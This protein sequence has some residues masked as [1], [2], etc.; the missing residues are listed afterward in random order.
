M[1]HKEEHASM[2]TTTY[3]GFSV[4]PKPIAPFD[5]FP[6]LMTFLDGVY[7]HINL[8][9]DDLSLP[10]LEKAASLQVQ[11]NRLPAC[12]VLSHDCFYSYGLDGDVSRLPVIP[13]CEGIVFYALLKL[14]HECDRVEPMED[15]LARLN[16]YA[17]LH[18]LHRGTNLDF[19]TKKGSALFGQKRVPRN[20]PQVCAA[21]GERKGWHVDRGS[22]LRTWVVPVT[23]ACENDTLCAS[24]ER[25]LQPHKLGA[26]HY[27]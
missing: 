25:P 24:C 4:S 27:G 7:V 18:T 12:L 3:P 23:C 2:A 14:P 6:Y 15:R 5:G 11:R 9:S 16:R 17:A 21:C 1:S 8:L 19:L 26:S 13:R 20:S 10:E 22:G